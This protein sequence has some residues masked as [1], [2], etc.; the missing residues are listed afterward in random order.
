[1]LKKISI[2]DIIKTT[3]VAGI[4]IILLPDGN[5][6]IN[7][8]V[9]KKTKIALTTEKQKEGIK[10][11]TELAQFIGTEL[12]IVLTLNG[13]G[14]VHRKISYSETDTLV[15]LINKVLPNANLNEF[16]LQ[17]TF[18]SS[19][20]VFISLIRSTSVNEVL[21][22]LKK[23]KLIQITNCLLGPFSI[24]NL[25]P[26]I[27]LSDAQLN[28]GIYQLQINERQITDVTILPEKTSEAVL[29]GD[30]PI[31]SDLLIAFA[32]ALSHFT[33]FDAGIINSE[34]INAVKEE[35]K[36]K[37]KFKLT[38]GAILIAM[39][40]ILFVNYFA[41]DHYWT[42]SRNMST[43]LALNQSALNRCNTLKAEYDRKKEFLEQNGLLESS[44][45]S[46]YADKLAESL[47]TS[48]QWTDVNIRPLKK[49]KDADETEGLLFENKTIKISGK[50]QRST[51][52]NNWMKQLKSKSWINTIALVNYKQ[53]S[54]DDEGMFSIEIKLV[55]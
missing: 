24:N 1:M 16:N 11:F 37:Q 35:F 13:K 33:T 42:K 2:E 28:V 52:L 51:D 25:I 38:R 53:S 20:Q 9:L 41:F 31:P 54:E 10:D 46:F 6:E 55:N 3:T 49:K 27:S 8:V 18:I 23:N 43:T 48:I 14:I 21:E 50:C 47:P 5:Y 7:A 36:Q 34:E 30:E 4:E 29:I 32:T 17:Q 26:L 45:T 22:E 15:T 40:I 44:R 19:S 39:F 12:P